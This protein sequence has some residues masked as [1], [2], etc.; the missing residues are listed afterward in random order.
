MRG[1]DKK[2]QTAAINC[3]EV[4]V[5]KIYLDKNVDNIYWTLSVY[6]L[7]NAPVKCSKNHSDAFHF[8]VYDWRRTIKKLLEHHQI[9]F[10]IV[11]YFTFKGN[12]SA[13]LIEACGST[14]HDTK[15]YDTLN[16]PFRRDNSP[17]P[18]TRSS[19]RRSAEKAHDPMSL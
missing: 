8:M 1:S 17:T 13:P 6:S 3:L 11:Q 10:S 18:V 9:P 12:S 16:Q 4:L 2:S 19:S 7:E 5:P 14:G 15:V